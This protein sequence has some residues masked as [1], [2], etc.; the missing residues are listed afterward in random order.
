MAKEL[1]GITPCVCHLCGFVKFQ[2]YV[3]TIYAGKSS[4]F[5][6]SYEVR[7]IFLL[8]ASSQIQPIAQFLVLLKTAKNP[9]IT[10]KNKHGNQWKIN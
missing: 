8:L 6:V 3:R 1:G 10:R 2:G 7:H 9:G 5:G 4:G